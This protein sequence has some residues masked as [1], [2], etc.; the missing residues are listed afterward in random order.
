MELFLKL[1]VWV[2]D[3]PHCRVRVET[4]GGGIH[5]M[6]PG[7][8]GF[9][10]RRTSGSGYTPGPVKTVH[11]CARCVKV[12]YALPPPEPKRLRGK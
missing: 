7:W 2:C 5:R 12:G 9:A 3:N 4:E 10:I 8:E 6:P 11:L 1:F